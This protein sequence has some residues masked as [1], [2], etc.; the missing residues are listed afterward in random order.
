MMMSGAGR[1]ILKLFL[2]YAAGVGKT[3]QM[4]EEG[5][6]LKEGG[7][8]VVIGYFEPHGRRETIAKT[9][10]LEIV[11]RARIVHRGSPFEEMDTNAIL[12]RRP[13][14]CLVDEFAHTNVPGSPRGKRWEDV[15]VLRDA[16]IHVLAT[17]NIQ[18]LGSLNDQVRQFTGVRVRETIPDWVVQRADEVVLVDLTPRALLNRLERGVIYNRGKVAEARRH[19]FRESALVNLRELA[20]RETAHELEKRVVGE[21]GGSQVEEASLPDGKA[22]KI[23]ALVTADPRTAMLIRRARR[24][25]DY[26]GAECFVVAV[27]AAGWPDTLPE[28]YREAIERHLN[29]ARNL[30]LETRILEGKDLERTLVD[31]ARRNQVTQLYLTRPEERPWNRFLGRGLLQRIVRLARDMQIVIVSER[32][33]E[34]D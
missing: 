22:T 2:G 17:L 31:F 23:L 28:A 21:K 33:A 14:V 6:A 27:R 11:P 8:D 19:F 32:D 5:H 12:A 1:G 30:R 16:G 9:E 4:L 18:H 34:T 7:E 20:L 26:L 13:R 15:E 24:M 10:G 29:F 25:S 3:F